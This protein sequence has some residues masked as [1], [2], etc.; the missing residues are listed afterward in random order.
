LAERQ[1]QE[2]VGLEMLTEKE[3]FDDISEA[4]KDFENNRVFTSQ[5]IQNCLC[6]N[7]NPIQKMNND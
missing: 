5:Q 7:E 3:I 1:K 2:M 4:E 6:I